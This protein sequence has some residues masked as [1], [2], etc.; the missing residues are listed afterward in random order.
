MNLDE[1]LERRQVAVEA[2]PLVNLA[3]VAARD[4]LGLLHHAALADARL[5]AD[6]HQRWGHLLVGDRPPDA[7]NGGAR[8]RSLLA[9]WSGR[10]SP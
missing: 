5:A 4:P 6:D 8:R 2:T 9:L 1:R 3:A 10:Q 7:G